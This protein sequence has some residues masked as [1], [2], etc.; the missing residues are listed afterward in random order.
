MNE[1]GSWEKGYLKSLKP[2]GKGIWVMQKS[3][4]ELI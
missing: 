1:F 2:N 4:E 3:N